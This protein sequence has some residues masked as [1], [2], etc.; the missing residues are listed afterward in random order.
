MSNHHINQL[1]IHKLFIRTSFRREKASQ[2]TMMV[3]S[4]RRLFTR[5]PKGM[6]IWERPWEGPEN[7]RQIEEHS[8]TGRQC[9]IHRKTFGMIARL[10]GSKWN[11]SLPK[12]RGLLAKSKEKQKSGSQEKMAMKSNVMNK[13]RAKSVK[14][15]ERLLNLNDWTQNSHNT[16][17]IFSNI[18]S[19]RSPRTYTWIDQVS[20]SWKGRYK[21]FKGDLGA[22]HI[23]NSTNGHTKL[24]D[25]SKRKKSK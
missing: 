19:W 12:L 13:T 10:L 4:G 18:L 11:T 3:K 7:K 23:I 16:W 8:S 24:D 14:L 22:Y 2:A 20:H 25:L 9:F 15:G 5:C 1:V 17:H 6:D 21:S